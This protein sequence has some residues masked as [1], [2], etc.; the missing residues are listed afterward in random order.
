MCDDTIYEDH[1]DLL[2]DFIGSRA[3]EHEDSN[4]IAANM[5][6]REL[7]EV[8]MMSP[9]GKSLDFVEWFDIKGKDD[10]QIVDIAGR[11][12]TYIITISLN[13]CDMFNDITKQLINNKGFKSYLHGLIEEANQKLNKE[14]YNEQ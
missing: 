2:R 11:Y 4:T 8:V 3:I 12:R 9:M 1:N 5:S 14:L 10:D 7:V 6:N 13:D